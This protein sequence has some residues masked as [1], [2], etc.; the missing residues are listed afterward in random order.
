MKLMR[1]GQLLRNLS[2]LLLEVR[3]AQDLGDALTRNPA[4]FGDHVP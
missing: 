4:A 3:S 1:S 2:S